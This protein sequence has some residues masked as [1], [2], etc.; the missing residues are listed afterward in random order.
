MRQLVAALALLGV[1]AVGAT[2]CSGTPQSPQATAPTTAA[3]GI[4]TPVECATAAT[5]VRTNRAAVHRPG[6]H[7]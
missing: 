4:T 7:T 5:S 3:H 2:G 1:A 6:R